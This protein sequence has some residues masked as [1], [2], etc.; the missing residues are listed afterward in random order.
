MLQT[1]DHDKCHGYIPDCRTVFHIHGLG[2]STADRIRIFDSMYSVPTQ[3][4][5]THLALNV[6]LTPRTAV[7]IHFLEEW[8]KRPQGNLQWGQLKVFEEIINHDE[9]YVST[10]REGTIR[11]LS[12]GVSPAKEEE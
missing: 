12:C 7:Q 3:Y 10:I 4:T 1:P 2:G 9:K 8:F 5:G 6:C 11:I